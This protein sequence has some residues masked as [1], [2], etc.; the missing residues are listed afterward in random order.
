MSA[1]LQQLV[2]A[3]SAKPG[4]GKQHSPEPASDADLVAGA[5]LTDK[6]ARYLTDAERALEVLTSIVDDLAKLAEDERAD[7]GDPEHGS[8][9]AAGA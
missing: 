3:V 2:G 5:T 7:G 9:A 8:I 4:S 6:E 1:A